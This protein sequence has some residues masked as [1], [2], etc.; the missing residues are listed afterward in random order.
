MRRA[1][2][3]R[4]GRFQ[5]LPWFVIQRPNL[6][7]GAVLILELGEDVFAQEKTAK[8]EGVDLQCLFKITKSGKCYLTFSKHLMCPQR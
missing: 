7:L 5:K 3:V 2:R 6:K 8:S 4:K 1:C